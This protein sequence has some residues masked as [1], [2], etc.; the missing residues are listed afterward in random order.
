[1]IGTGT[2]EQAERR[3][4]LADLYLNYSDGAVRLALRGSFIPIRGMTSRFL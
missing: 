2:L 4:R 1:M 3:G